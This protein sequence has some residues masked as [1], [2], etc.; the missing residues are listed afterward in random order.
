MVRRSGRKLPTRTLRGAVRNRLVYRNDEPSLAIVESGCPWSFGGDG[1]LLRLVS[2]AYRIRLD[3]IR[4]HMEAVH[5]APIL[6][7]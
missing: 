3:L 6:F 7:L 2:D 4:D 1:A 5:S